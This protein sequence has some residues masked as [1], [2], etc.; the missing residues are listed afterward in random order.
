M[1][2]LR[3]REELENLSHQN[4]GLI[5]LEYRIK[6]LSTG[7][8]MVSNRED[9]YKRLDHLTDISRKSRFQL[10][11]VSNWSDDIAKTISLN[12]DLIKSVNTR[13]E[14]AIEIMDKKRIN[15]TRIISADDEEELFPEFDGSAFPLFHRFMAN[16]NE[17]SDLAAIPSILRT[18][19]LLKCL[20]GNAK[21][22][23]NRLGIVPNDTFEEVVHLL[24]MY[25]GDLARQKEAILLLQQQIGHI[26]SLSRT[27]VVKEDCHMVLSKQLRILKEVHYL[28]ELFDEGTIPENPLDSLFISKLESPFPRDLLFGPEFDQSQ[29]LIERLK[30]LIKLC[31]RIKL[32]FLKE[33]VVCGISKRPPTNV[34]CDL[35]CPTSKT[36]EGQTQTPTISGTKLKFLERK[37]VRGGR[38]K[39]RAFLSQGD[40]FNK[41]KS[42]MISGYREDA[43][44]GSPEVAMTPRNN[45]SNLR[46]CKNLLKL[47][48]YEN[49]CPTS[50]ETSSRP[51]RLRRKRHRKK[52]IPPLGT[53]DHPQYSIASRVGDINNES[54]HIDGQVSSHDGSQNLCDKTDSTSISDKVEMHDS[55]PPV[56]NSLFTKEGEGQEILSNLKI[57]LFLSLL[58]S[59]K[60]DVEIKDAVP[61]EFVAKTKRYNFSRM[62][63]NLITYFS[64]IFF[65]HM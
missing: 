50:L 26:P 29:P 19:R 55:G 11:N 65:L 33:I 18:R 12:K 31:E 23:A 9:L 16:F 61:I 53:A 43:L 62:I 35:D 41:A 45:G 48:P 42:N 28:Y 32:I 4:D 39:K 40:G 24:K 8:L 64:L 37:K 60:K 30:S 54:Y 13:L 20:K 38:P 56:T 52:Q 44:R 47:K 36:K 49:R 7:A 17:I 15:L 1:N 14:E 63:Y 5:R 6:K 2:S 21:L 25:F 3:L 58:I 46:L 27:D 59:I 34:A 51:K 22:I 10:L 57:L